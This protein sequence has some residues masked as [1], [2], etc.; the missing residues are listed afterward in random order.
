MS[1]ASGKAAPRDL[2]QIAHLLAQAKLPPHVIV[3]ASHSN[4]GKCH[5]R[6]ADVASE[7]AERLA[8]GEDRIAG[9][10]LESYLQGGRQD[11]SAHQT[12]SHVYGCSVTDACISWDTT[13]S[14]L[15]QFAA[16]IADRRALINPYTQRIAN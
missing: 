16:A 1:A 2:A 13:V 4:S 15:H 12:A 11:I 6:Q 10:M 7:L 8:G 9:V 14:V 3:D 5:H